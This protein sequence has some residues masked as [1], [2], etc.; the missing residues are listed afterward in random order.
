MFSMLDMFTSVIFFCKTERT[1]LLGIFLLD[2]I[3]NL[4]LILLG[5]FF[6]CVNFSILLLFSYQG[7]KSY[8]GSS[9]SVKNPLMNLYPNTLKLLLIF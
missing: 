8:S 6:G 5:G 2:V 1:V 3:L 4:N 9:N 7:L